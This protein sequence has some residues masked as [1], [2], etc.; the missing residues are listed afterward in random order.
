[1]AEQEKDAEDAE[2]EEADDGDVGE[3]EDLLDDENAESAGAG[4]GAS[5]GAAKPKASA[6]GGRVKAAM[7]K[8]REERETHRRQGWL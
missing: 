2:E 6:R 3:D 8:R 1:M 5:A 7:T 4:A